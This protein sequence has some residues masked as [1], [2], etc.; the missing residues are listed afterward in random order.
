MLGSGCTDPGDPMAEGSTGASTTGGATTSTG[1]LSQTGIESSGAESTTDGTSG[2]VDSTGSTSTGSTAC[3]LSEVGA[4]MPVGDDCCG[5]LCGASG[6]SCSEDTCL[7]PEGTAD[8]LAPEAGFFEL[9]SYPYAWE[10]L[11]RTSARQRVWYSFWPADD[12]PSTRPL[13]L[14]FNGG[15]GS[16]TGLLFGSNTA[17]YTLDPERTDSVMPTDLPWTQQFNLLYVDAPS[18][19]FSYNLPLDDGTQIPV[20]IDPEQDASAFISVL[21]RFLARHPALQ[22]NPVIILGESYGG[23]RGTLML[24]QLLDYE[25]LVDG[26]SIYQNESVYGEIE[27][28]LA[29]LYPETCGVGVT[30]EQVAAQFGHFVSVQGVVAGA[31]QLTEP[32]VPSPLCLP[33][34]DIYHCNRPDGWLFGV[35]A[36]IGARL[37]QP[38]IL[39]TVLGADPR[40]I[41]WMHADARQ[42]A[43]GREV[44][45]DESEMVSIFGPLG[46]G[47]A[48]Y[49]DLN[50]AV[51][52]P[53]PG[54][55]NFWANDMADIF[56]RVVAGA[57]VLATD[58]RLDTV[59]PVQTLAPVLSDRVMAVTSVV[60]DLAPRPGVDRPGWFQ[61]EYVPGWAPDGVTMAEIRAPLYEEAG[62]TVPL[63][64]PEFLL[65]DITAWLAR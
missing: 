50:F 40:T 24:Q 15:P 60:H 16:S 32:F 11:A 56:L 8:G 27:R 41:A 19:G 26:V 36:E 38:D 4:V 52:S 47:D 46:P 45:A 61:V 39:D 64:D 49:V 21:L 3:E 63:D 59:V 31:P 55:R 12:E 13:V 28:H 34:G 6:W 2:A 48:F 42:G 29:G 10:D 22:Y 25:T 18:T 51:N 30:R 5:C 43:Y 14:L 65:E 1:E 54:S 20:S 44:V 7:L 17:P 23:V 58:A 33:G 35:S 57:D 37:R 53:L 9:M 62:H